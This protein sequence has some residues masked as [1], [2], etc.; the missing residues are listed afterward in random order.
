MGLGVSVSGGI[1]CPSISCP[2]KSLSDAGLGSRV[3][4]SSFESVSHNGKTRWFRTRG[5]GVGA[6]T[7]RDETFGASW[8]M[9]VVG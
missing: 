7:S 3:S 9:A 1:P 5:K 4:R 6:D 8:G 2:L